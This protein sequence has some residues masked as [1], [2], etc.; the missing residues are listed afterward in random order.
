MTEREIV[1]RCNMLA[2]CFYAEL[3]YAVVE[4]YRFDNADHPQEQS[5]WNMACI[6]FDVLLD[7]D[8][9]N[10]IMELEDSR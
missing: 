2:R 10:A 5:C 6:A 9:E 8:V 1:D 7:T 4:G 3:G